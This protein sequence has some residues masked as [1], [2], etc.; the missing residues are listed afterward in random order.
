M[1]AGDYGERASEPWSLRKRIVPLRTYCGR[2]VHDRQPHYFKIKDAQR[3]LDKLQPPEA[4]DAEKWSNSVLR[5]L[6]H[7]T[8]VM[9]DKILPFLDTKDVENLYE[10]GVELLDRLFRID[11][12]NKQLDFAARRLIQG[13]ADRFGYTVTLK[14]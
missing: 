13:I 10:V 4:D 12:D 8:I 3:I 9:L 6:R 14:K 5:F 1:Q 2:V 7:A 11:A